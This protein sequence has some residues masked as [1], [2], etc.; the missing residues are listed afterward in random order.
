MSTHDQER[1]SRKQVRL[2]EVTYD[3]AINVVSNEMFRAE[4][5]CSECGEKGVWAPL[6]GDPIRAAELAKLGLEVHH[7]FLHCGIKKKKPR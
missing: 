5:T 6:S 4:W 3:I 7:S 1:H 2:G